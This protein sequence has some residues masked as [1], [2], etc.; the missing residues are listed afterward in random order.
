M[1]EIEVGLLEIVGITARGEIEARS[2]LN[3]FAEASRYDCFQTKRAEER[4]ERALLS[5]AG[6]SFLPSDSR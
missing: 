5:G 1:S 6:R 4:G 2:D 3:F